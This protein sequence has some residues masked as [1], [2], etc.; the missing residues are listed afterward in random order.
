MWCWLQCRAGILSPTFISRMNCEITDWIKQSCNFN[1]GKEGC[2]GRAGS[3]LASVGFCSGRNVLPR[4]SLQGCTSSFSFHCEPL[5]FALH[6]K[7]GWKKEKWVVYYAANITKDIFCGLKKKKKGKEKCK[8]VAFPLFSEEN[9]I[10]LVSPR[11]HIMLI[12][13]CIWSEG[14]WGQCRDSQYL[15]R[16][17]H[18]T[19]QELLF[20]W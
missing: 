14:H 18:H 2:V 12:F 6:E 17:L 5:L 1:W 19:E 16:A 9:C 13:L 20:C 4:S 11:W 8:S 15:Q 3:P 10:P 7:R